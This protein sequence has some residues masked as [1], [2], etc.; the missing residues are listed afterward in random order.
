MN[1]MLSIM[2]S[3]PKIYYNIYF[4]KSS[5]D[6]KSRG[7]NFHSVI[8]QFLLLL[9]VDDSNVLSTESRDLFSIKVISIGWR[10][11]SM[12]LKYYD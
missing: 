11:G 1:I 2:A 10:W 8:N 12:W 5:S 6:T 7:Y 3:K 9:P 4:W